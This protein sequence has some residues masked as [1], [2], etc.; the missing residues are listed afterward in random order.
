MKSK[1]NSPPQA[2]IFKV[3]C[4][5]SYNN[6]RFCE[7]IQGIIR[8]ALK[9][10]QEDSGRLSKLLAKAW[11]IL[12]GANRACGWHP[13]VPRASWV[14]GMSSYL[15]PS[16]L[17][18]G[19]EFVIH[20]PHSAGSGDAEMP[21]ARSVWS[22]NIIQAFGQK[23]EQSPGVSISFSKSIGKCSITFLRHPHVLKIHGKYQIYFWWARKCS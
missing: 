7:I 1:G 9:E 16:R 4:S 23:L 19:I 2:E 21:S 14:W 15:P 11:Q 20:F 13:C 6:L 8:M 22:E 10:C 17:S 12:S 3:L 18:A 5:K